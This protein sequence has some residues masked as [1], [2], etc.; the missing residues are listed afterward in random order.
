MAK[1]TI[2][3]I[4]PNIPGYTWTLGYNIY[5]GRLAVVF[6]RTDRLTDGRAE[7]DLYNVSVTFEAITQKQIN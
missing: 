5:T 1:Q 2:V 7:H 4:Y 6:H 3:L